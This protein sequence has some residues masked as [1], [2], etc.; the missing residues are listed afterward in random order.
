VKA[1][2]LGDTRGAMNTLKHSL[3]GLASS[4]LFTVGCTQVAEKMD[5]TFGAQR[6]VGS[7]TGSPAKPCE[8][9]WFSAHD[10]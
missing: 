5:R 1:A 4:L 7:G 6:A 9:C 10:Q 8:I 2:N 3:S